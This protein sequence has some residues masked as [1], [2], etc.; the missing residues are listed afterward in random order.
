[1]NSKVS[2]KCEERTPEAP[3]CCLSEGAM[4]DLGGTGENAAVYL[5]LDGY[6]WKWL[7]RIEARG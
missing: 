4:D 7:P 3:G 1:M 6:A 2:V 5:E